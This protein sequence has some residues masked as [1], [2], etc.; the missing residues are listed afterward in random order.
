V[1]VPEV[2]LAEV[3]A[4]DFA[5]GLYAAASMALISADVIAPALHSQGSM[6]SPP[7]LQPSSARRPWLRAPPLQPQIGLPPC[8]TSRVAPAPIPPWA[9]PAKL[10]GPRQQLLKPAP[11]GAARGAANARP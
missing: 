5:R 9:S 3:H 1:S 4:I 10:Q 7:L 8:M 11:K 6:C 2:A